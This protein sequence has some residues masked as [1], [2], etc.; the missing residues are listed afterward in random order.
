MNYSARNIIF[1]VTTALITLSSG[2]PALADDTELF[3]G[4]ASAQAGA[5]PNLLFILDNSGSMGAQ[6]S[7]SSGTAESYD[8]LV[9][10]P[11]ACDASRTYY[12]TGGGGGG[13]GRLP[14]PPECLDGAY[15]N[16]TALMCDAAGQPLA[17][18]GFYTDTL[19]RYDTNNSDPDRHQWEDLSTLEKDQ[20]VE[21]RADEGDHGGTP[22]PLTD[23]YAANANNN[24]PWSSVQ[25]DRIR[26]W[27]RNFNTTTL[28]TANYLNYYW[29]I[30]V[31]QNRTKLEIVQAAAVDLLNSMNNVNVGLINFDTVSQQEGG[32]VI[33][34]MG[35]I[36]TARA[37]MISQ[38]NGMTA[39][40]WTPLSETL[41]EAGL[42]YMGDK[43]DYGDRNRLSVDSSRTVDGIYQ[44]PILYECQNNFVI[45]LTDGEP[46]Q[47]TSA[48]T[49]IAALNG[50]CDANPSP[51]TTQDGH[52]L[53]DMSQ[54]M[55]ENDLMP[56]MAGVQNV[57]TYTIGFDTNFPLISSTAT[58]GGGEFYL[59]NDAKSLANVLTAIVRNILNTQT[60]FVAPTVSVNAFNR[61][62]TR[63]DLY[64]ALFSP[65]THESWPGNLKKFR[66][67]DGQIVGRD[68][69]TPVVDPLTGFLR[70]NS[71]S[72][73]STA[74]DG[75]NVRAGGAASQ[76]PAPGSRN[77]LTALNP[78]S[79]VLS[80]ISEVNAPLLTFLE[81]LPDVGT[82]EIALD[83]VKHIRGVDVRDENQNNDRT[84]QRHWMGDPLH[85]KPEMITYGGTEGA[86]DPEDNV[87]YAATNDG[88][89]HAID[90]S[91]GVEKWAFIPHEMLELQPALYWNATYSTRRYG[92]DGNVRSVI[93]DVNQD[94][95]INPDAGDRAYLFF[96]LRRGGSYYYG[97][98]ITNQD[99]PELMWSLS[100]AD[101]PN[102]GQTWSTPTPMRVKIAGASQNDRQLALA[103]GAGYDP[104]QD[105]GPYVEDTQGNGIFIIDALSGNL[106]WHAGSSG[107]TNLT[108]ADFTNSIVSDIRALE[109][110]RDGLTD[111]LYATDVGGQVWRF[112][113]WNGESADNFATGGVIASLG[114]VANQTD[115]IENRRFYYAPDAALVTRGA[116]N[117]FMH[118]GV[119]SGYRAHPLDKSDADRFYAIRDF[120]PFSRLTQAEYDAITPLLDGDLV[121]VTTDITPNMA[122]GDPGWKIQLSA[123]GELGTG[124]K[125]LSESRTFADTVF[126]TT[127]TPGANVN[128]C[129]P[130]QGLN[131]LYAVSV[132]DGRPVNNLD[133]VGSDSDLTVDD[134]VQDLAMGGI[135]PEIVFLFPDPNACTTGDCQ[136]VYGFVGLEGIGNLNL[137]PYVRTYWEQAGSE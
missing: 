136:M 79:T 20:W 48:D 82:P 6:P 111:R 34:P 49:E 35:N 19:A 110:S 61:T 114:G 127:F 31:L 100:A 11:G 86:P 84:E 135:A 44:S 67:R 29:T 91:T 132:V 131:K 25:N 60:S 92:I 134:R 41:Y 105:N 74:P 18:T 106:L 5:Y 72:I 90:P 38:I 116:G 99:A 109:L 85:S 9:T 39:Q 89:L 113:L 3:V 120:N 27:N 65:D 10:Y 68:L 54:Y 40:T 103:F 97:L 26:N 51:M 47:D 96:G 16:T 42:Y 118:L 121:D 53:D 73:W 94:G 119:G 12:L 93:V 88:I 21:C 55:F 95:V 69:T 70:E 124:E 80:S 37:G 57:T 104:L 77:I 102:L 30:G 125:V 133:G 17:Q 14:D 98:N 13:R 56:D 62:Q 107:G 45:L 8:P 1:S 43:P 46:T 59:A 15:F 122:P 33:S 76:L 4:D 58:K 71:Q 64:V 78:A 28:Y 112:D 66:L 129:Q 130:G 126:F 24:G 2:A 108:S 83:V 117:R 32:D 128:P 87:L 75:D 52:C 7:G 137:P 22:N 81:A 50:S 63:D 123:G 23:V 101:L 36:A 115:T